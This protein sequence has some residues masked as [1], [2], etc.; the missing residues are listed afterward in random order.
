MLTMAS[1]SVKKR[2][3]SQSASSKIDSI[4][5]QLYLPMLCVPAPP[6]TSFLPEDAAEA[7]LRQ[8]AQERPG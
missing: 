6:Q 1:P 3:A 5:R 8:V 2:K 4:V 7:I